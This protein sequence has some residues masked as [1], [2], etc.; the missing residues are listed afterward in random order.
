MPSPGL[1]NPDDLPELR[2]LGA[3]GPRWRRPGGDRLTAFAPDRCRHITVQEQAYRKKWG[4][5]AYRTREMWGLQA[6]S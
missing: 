2:L 6:L 3:L 1:S 4:A 5:R